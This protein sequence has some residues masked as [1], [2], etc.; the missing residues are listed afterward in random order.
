MKPAKPPP[1]PIGRPPLVGARRSL[2]V[3][4]DDD[5]QRARAIG[6]TVSKGIRMALRKTAP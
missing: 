5:R 6:G 1:R 3:L 4:T 2:V